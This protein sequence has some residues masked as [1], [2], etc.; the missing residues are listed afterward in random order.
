MSLLDRLLTQRSLAL[1]TVLASIAT[2]IGLLVTVVVI[3]FQPTSPP[4]LNARG[5]P[6][7]LPG[8]SVVTPPPSPAENT[9]VTPSLA[10]SPSV[11]FSPTVEPTAE[12]V[13]YLDDYASE[14]RIGVST[15]IAK[16]NGTEYAHAIQQMGWHF[17]QFFQP[18]T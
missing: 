11:T 3:V 10:R 5:L 17:E 14:C 4:P 12:V 6:T 18:F 1:W 9:S 2:V 13:S 16:I 8:P 15:G 7:P